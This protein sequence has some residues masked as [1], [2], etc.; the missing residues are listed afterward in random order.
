MAERG[1]LF[2]RRA[3]FE[4][5]TGV[6]MGDCGVFAGGDVVL[7]CPIVYH[8]APELYQVCIMEFEAER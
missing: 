4:R 2:S 3:I 7:S 8:D 6:L 1:G 5:D